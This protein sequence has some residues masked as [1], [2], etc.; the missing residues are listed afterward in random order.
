MTLTL[1]IRGQGTLDRIGAPDLNQIP[2]IA[3]SFRVY[4]ST[5]ETARGEKRFTYSLRPQSA[6]TAEFPSIELSYFDVQQEKYVTLHS[7]P[8]PIQ[9][10]QAEQLASNQIAVASVPRQK[11][12]GLQASDE[13]IFANITDPSQFVNHSV[14][15][16]KWIGGAGS[17][18]GVYATVTLLVARSRRNRADPQRIRRR[19]ATNRAER[20]LAQAIELL[21]Q[22]Q[23]RRAAEEFTSLFTHLAADLAGISAAGMTVSD[24]S[25]VLREL[26]FPDDL[27]AQ[28]HQLLERCDAARFGA[29]GIHG[30]G[31][32]AAS[33]LRRLRA[34]IRERRLLR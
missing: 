10:S 2:P 3:N 9:I 4:E 20:K 21:E 28:C 19:S 11:V 25:R 13:G 31:A 17:M 16:R 14:D 26:Q 18:A 8:I 1:T 30:I 7:E 34:V 32:D 12:A 6:D 27:V 24:F 5:S 29:G 22:R 23:E 33:L 15:V